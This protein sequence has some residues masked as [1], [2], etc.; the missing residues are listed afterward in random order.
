MGDNEGKWPS[1]AELPKVGD[2]HIGCSWELFGAGDELGS[3]N[4]LPVDAPLRA[5]KE[6][7]VG[8][9]VNLD[10]ALDAFEPFPS[11]TR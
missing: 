11:G 7:Q 9:V 3:L 6:I 2:A 1:Y 5:A 4:F 10:F 8:K